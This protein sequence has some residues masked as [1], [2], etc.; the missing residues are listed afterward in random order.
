MSYTLRNGLSFCQVDGGLVFLDIDNDRYFR[1]PNQLERT[2]VESGRNG[3][4]MSPQIKR[5]VDM[6]ILVENTVSEFKQAV[7]M[8]D[9]ACRSAIEQG[10]DSK[11]PNMKDVVD[12]FST[13]ISTRWLLKKNCLKHALNL[14]TSCQQQSA[15]APR[16]YPSNLGDHEIGSA[17]RIF[18]RTRPYVPIE[19]CCLLDSLAMVRFL[20]RRSLRANIVFGVTRDPFSAHC[21][22][23]TK[24]LVLND[25]VGSTKAYVPIRVC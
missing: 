1:L 25:T 17:A 3:F 9:E 24:D 15:P 2:F 7:S 5:L 19:P 12:V 16:S 11:N 20:A 22:V 14:A 8:L 4:P 6:E 18:I 23:Q 13:V 21:W 10:T